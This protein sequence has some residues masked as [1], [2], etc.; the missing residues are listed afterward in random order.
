MMLKLKL[1]YVG[2]LMRRVDSL[3]RTLMLGGIGGRRRRGRQR[4]R[5]LDGIT[6]SMDVSLS[7]V[8][9][10]VMDREAWCA[11]IHGVAK[12]RTRLINWTELNWCTKYHTHSTY[13]Y[14]IPSY[15]SQLAPRTCTH[16]QILQPEKKEFH[17]RILL[18]KRRKAQSFFENCHLS[19]NSS[20][21]AS[22]ILRG[23]GR[24]VKDSEL[25]KEMRT[26]WEGAKI[27][28]AHAYIPVWNIL[29]RT[30]NF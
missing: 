25:K 17:I 27:Y 23:R 8:R 5:W 3:E 21:E 22:A 15:T 16:W 12:S 1:Q 11:V 28:D 4:M 2:H 19:V 24:K 9:E 13:T 26:G 7:E 20:L 10:L 18:L 30:S 29:T 6:D 14:H